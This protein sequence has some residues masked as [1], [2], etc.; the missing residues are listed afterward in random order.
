MTYG[1]GYGYEK[2]KK[3]GR[4]PI[5]DGNTVGWY[6]ASDLTT[7]TKDGANLVSRW[8][9]KLGSG[10]DLLQ[11]VVLN[12]PLW[13]LNDGILFDGIANFMKTAS[14][15]WDQPEFIY[16]VLKQVT[17]TN[18]DIIFDGNTGLSGAFEQYPSTPAL[19]TNNGGTL[20]PN[21]TNLPVNTFGIVRVL[22]NGVNSKII[23]NDTL[24]V[25]GN[26]GVNNM[27]GFTLGTRGSI[28]AYSNIQVKEIICRNVF[29]NESDETAIYNY[30]KSKYQL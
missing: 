24:P 3:Y 17:W 29:D 1:Y 26:F 15:T 9:D 28:S 8:N 30:L 6:I 16:I 20:S 21:N 18:L 10:R 11:A 22:F 27:S 19:I 23:V 12:Q 5:Y 25:T 2:Y 13:V 4:L 7:I 14:F